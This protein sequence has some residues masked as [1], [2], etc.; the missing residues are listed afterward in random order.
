[1]FNRGDSSLRPNNCPHCCFFTF[2]EDHWLQ[3]LGQVRDE[4]MLAQFELI[5]Y[6]QS[7]KTSCT[8]AALTSR[9]DAPK[10]RKWRVSHCR[11]LRTDVGAVCVPLINR[12]VSNLP[13]CGGAAASVAC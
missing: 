11:R 2:T 9:K 5:G 4:A 3:E 13:L 7:S 10:K 6:S 1:M 8:N 12:V